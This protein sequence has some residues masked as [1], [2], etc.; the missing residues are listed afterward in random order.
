MVRIRHFDVGAL[1]LQ[2]VQL[3]QKVAFM[4]VPGTS[5]FAD[6]MT[7]HLPSDSI[8][9]YMRML[10]YEFRDGRSKVAAELHR[11]SAPASSSK[12]LTPRKKETTTQTQDTKTKKNKKQQEQQ[13][14]S[15]SKSV[16]VA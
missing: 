10:G 3:R 12:T 8:N 4:K 1:W 6:L 7:K 16:E 14:L 13:E 5:N 11:T 15:L 9:G 2:E